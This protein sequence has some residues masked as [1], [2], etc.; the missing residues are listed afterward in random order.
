MPSRL[1]LELA[2]HRAPAPMGP[3]PHAQAQHRTARDKTL[4]L[5]DQTTGGAG[6]CNYDNWGVAIPFMLDWL[7]KR[8]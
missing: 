1:E 6:H 8:L 4:K 2:G 7:A 5:W 3:E